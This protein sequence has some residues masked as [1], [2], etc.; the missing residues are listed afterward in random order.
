MMAR[1]QAVRMAP[2]RARGGADA[3]GGEPV[4]GR[5]GRAAAAPLFPSKR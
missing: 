2:V 5:R 3:G 1:G 4:A